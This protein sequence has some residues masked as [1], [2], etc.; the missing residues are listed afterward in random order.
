MFF[1]KIFSFF[2]TDFNE[3]YGLKSVYPW[4]LWVMVSIAVMPLFVWLARHFFPKIRWLHSVHIPIMFLYLRYLESPG[5]GYL[6]IPVW[7]LMGLL[8]RYV[9]RRW[10]FDRYG[11]LFSLTITMGDRFA[12]MLV[13]LIFT[14]RNQKFPSWWG[15]GTN[16]CPFSG[17]SMNGSFVS[18]SLQ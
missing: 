4:L 11:F 12:R 14:N 2:V 15:T 7:I 3:M 13:F 5:V 1:L 6:Q 17:A 18:S 9:I 8:F 10:W 16:V